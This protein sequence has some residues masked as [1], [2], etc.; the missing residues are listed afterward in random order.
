MDSFLRQLL[1]LF[2]Q[3]LPDL[4][5]CPLSLL[6]DHLLLGERF[7]RAGLRV[8]IVSGT[9]RTFLGVLFLPVLRPPVLE[10]DR[11]PG[12]LQVELERDGLPHEDVRVVTGLEDSLQLLQLPLAEVRPG[13]SPLVIFALGV[14]NNM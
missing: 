4:L 7:S 2:L 11:D 3:L 10:P 5:L 6:A 13:A 1:L 8:S 12:L 14:C 9:T